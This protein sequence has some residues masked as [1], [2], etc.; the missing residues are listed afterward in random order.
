MVGTARKL[1]MLPL[2]QRHRWFGH[3]AVIASFAGVLI[4]DYLS[5]PGG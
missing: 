4:A 3:P 1:R 5:T 2:G